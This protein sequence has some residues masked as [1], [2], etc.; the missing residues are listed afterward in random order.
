MR[1]SGK[2]ILTSGGQPA[3]MKRFWI[4]WLLVLAA[5][6]TPGQQF[7]GIS[8][9]RVV[10]DGSVFDVRIRPDVAQAIRVNPQYAP[11]F[12][13]IRDRAAFAMA[14]VSGCKVSRVTGDQSV[15]LGRLAC[16]GRPV[17]PARPVIASSFSCLELNQWLQETTGFG[18]TEFE[19][20]QI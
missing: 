4:I 16:K 17:V 5:C 2:E 11:R 14:Q 9:T 18:S 20:D 15:A 12:G 10:V 13:P 7:R 3:G 19:C 1:S 6:N 8:A